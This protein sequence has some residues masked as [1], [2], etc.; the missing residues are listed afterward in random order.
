[1]RAFVRAG[2]FLSLLFSWGASAAAT[3]QGLTHAPLPTTCIVGT[4]TTTGDSHWNN[5]SL[6]LKNNCGKTVDFQN[7]NITF[8]NTTALNTGFWG[9]FGPLTYPDN[10]LQISS[11]P[12][13]GGGFLASLS[14]HIP[15][16]D[17]A[18]SKLPSNG[19]ITLFYG[20]SKAAYTAASLQVYLPNNSPPSQTGEIDLTNQTAKPANVTQTYAV[21]DLKNNGTTVKSVQLNWLSTQALT[22][23]IPGA[24]TIQA[25]NLTDTQGNVYQGSAVPAT[26]NLAAGQKV[27]S[28][29][30]YAMQVTFGKINLQVSPLPSVLTGYPSNPVVTMTK[31]SNGSTSTK[32]VGWNATTVLDQLANQANYSFSTPDITFNNYRCAG[33]FTPPQAVSNAQT[34]PTVNLAYNC[35]A[36]SPVSVGVNVSGL[37]ATTTA[38]DVTFTPNDGATPVTK[39]VNLTNG[40]GSDTVLLTENLIY[41]V[42]S[43]QVSG[44]SASFLPQP[45]TAKNAAIEAIT[46]KVLPPP[47]SNTRIISYIPGWKQPPNPADMANAGYTHAMIAF[48]VFSSTSPGKIVS[49]FDTITKSYIDSLHAVGIKAVLS[50]G[51]ALTSIPNTSVDFHQ[52]LSLAS[53]PTVFQQTF[54]QSVKD[55]VTQFGFDGIDIDIEHGLNGAGPFQTPTGDI[56]VMANIL[57][58]LHADLPNLIISLTPQTANISA[59]SGYDGTWANYSALIMQTHDALSWVGIQLYNTGCMFGIDHVC[60]DPN[61][62]SSPNFSVAMA[63]DVLASWPQTDE[64]G[65]PTGFKPY[66]GYLR[67]DQVVL[68]YPAANAQG[69]SDGAPVTPTATIKKAIQCLKTAV[70]GTNSC[71]TYV[72]PK[73]YGLIGG[74]FNWEIT[75]D[76]ANQYKFAK[77]LKTC[78]MTGVCS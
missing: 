42:A 45:I 44:F 6:Q 2:L 43:T 57:N 19:S 67:A 74:A 61:Q 15:E 1:M 66:I 71:G 38:V 23:L 48:G 29:I 21:V 68:G 76:Q 3:Q 27:A 7:A 51:G 36:I 34:P 59:T 14:L 24:Y 65:R 25:N 40:S 32:S 73:A 22:G 4:F 20:V 9:T 11:Q 58:Q 53:S 30:S 18:N 47:S 49:S 75:Y 12:A 69:G 5:V 13:T 54:V 56:A 8:K 70:A 31:I 10:N 55:F 77:D 60:Y 37:T 35:V 63:T 52:V 26:I 46:Y 62:T 64:T 78:V 72:P 33:T 17:W 28:A 41:N 50:L 16:A 39:H